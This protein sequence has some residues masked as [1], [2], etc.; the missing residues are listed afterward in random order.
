MNGFLSNLYIKWSDQIT[1]LIFIFSLSSSSEY[2]YYKTG[3]PVTAHNKYWDIKV[4]YA[5]DNGGNYNFI[6]DPFTQRSLPND[7]TF[8]M[9]LFSNATKWGLKTYEQDWLNHQT[10]D[11]TPL[12]TNITL[13]RTW[14]KQM[15]NAALA[16]NITIQYCMSLSRHALQSLEID[17]VTQIRVTNDYATNFQYQGQQWRLGVSSIFAAALGLTP[18]K[19]VFW[20]TPE[21]PG[22]PY[23][24]KAIDKLV[25]LNAVISTLTGGPVG[26]GDRIDL[27]NKDLIMRSCNSDGLLLKPSRA[28][29]ST[30][31]QIYAKAFGNNKYG[32]EGEVWTTHSRIDEYTFGIIFATSMNGLI[33][34][35]ESNVGF[36]VYVI[37]IRIYL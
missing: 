36:D 19:D 17:A 13:G 23:G 20:T 26:P 24:P 8:W 12:M 25:R 34:M 6:L 9:D 5:T 21:Q 14:L 30:D 15:G 22:N 2:M 37:I 10:L 16:Y 31:E 18:F 33:Q 11:F 29:T 32:V 7:Q 1:C 27:M 4:E 28:A 3:L 35:N